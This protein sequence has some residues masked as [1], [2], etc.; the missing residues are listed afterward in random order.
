MGE[1]ISTAFSAVCLLTKNALCLVC[2]TGTYSIINLPV[3]L[4]SMN[5]DSHVEQRSL[6]G[7]IFSAPT[8]ARLQGGEVNLRA[9][10]TMVYSS[11]VGSS[12]RHDVSNETQR[13]MSG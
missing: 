6:V 2:L 10:G 1:Q 13:G 7:G 9:W 4:F 3:S 8:G 12:R 11:I 5:L